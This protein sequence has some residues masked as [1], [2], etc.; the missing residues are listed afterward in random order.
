MYG[1]NITS[2]HKGGIMPRKKTKKGTKSEERVKFLTNVGNINSKKLRNNATKWELLL[3]K[4]LS[5]LHYNFKFQVP[6]ICG[7]K[8]LYIVD[9]LLVDYNIFIEAD[10]KQHY[11]REGMRR[12]NRRTKNLKKEGYAPLRLSNKQ[13][14]LFSKETIDQAIRTAIQ[15]SQLLKELK[16]SKV[17]SK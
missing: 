16:N 11:T 8:N 17:S 5:D 12:D 3:K 9:F 15:I 13:I 6:I 10:G 7:K 1:E 4:A 14:S 2:N